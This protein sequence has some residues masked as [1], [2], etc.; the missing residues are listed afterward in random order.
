MLAYDV[1]Q[2][3]DGGGDDDG[4]YKNDSVRNPQRPSVAG[5]WYVWEL[6]Q[7]EER[8]SDYKAPV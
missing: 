8:W 5:V 7:A 4:N 6:V 2:Y 1:D 3:D